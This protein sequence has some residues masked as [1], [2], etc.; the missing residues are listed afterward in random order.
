MNN[1][2]KTI[3]SDVIEIIGGGTPKTSVVEYWNGDIPWLSVVDFNDD[4][5][6][7]FKT[8]KTITEDGLKN[9][10]TKLL[11]AGDIIVSARGTVGALAQLKK[12]MAFNQ[13]CYGLR[14]IDS[15]AENNF[16]YYLVKYNLN[17]IKKMVH[18]AVFD[19]ITKQTFD[20]ID[21]LLPPLP[22][23]RAIAGV[24]SGFDDKIELLRAENK[25]LENIAQTIFKE[26]FVKDESNLP[27]GWRVGMFDDIV[28]L[29]T[30]KGLKKEDLEPHGMYPVLGA[31][32]EIG[33]TNEYLYDEDL[34]LVGRVG[35]LGKVYLSYGKVWISDNVLISKPRENKFFHYAYFVLKSLDFNSMNRGSTQPLV[36][37]GD[38]KK[39]KVILTDEKTMNMW[40]HV[41]SVLFIKI[42]NNNSQIQTLA[43]LRDTILP[44]L[45][46]G[47][48][49]IK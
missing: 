3:L 34:I 11:N 18:G 9:S 4:S 24:L 12:P 16:L 21:I 28:D 13:S 17:Q 39:V 37:Q 15:K 49:D 31:N 7:V 10:P 40:H 33:K 35:T 46:S 8:E 6:W 19:T 2:Q 45:M 23:Q 22:T 44:K 5:R 41:V 20:E 14:A 47:E 36:T 30:G 1:W 26:W 48:V 38:L 43:K 25:T 27:A 29:T 42:K 32:G